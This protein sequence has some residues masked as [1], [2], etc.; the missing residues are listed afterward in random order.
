[1][2][3]ERK[4]RE[5][6]REREREREREHCNPSHGGEKALARARSERARVS[7]RVSVRETTTKKQ[8]K[9]MV[10]GQKP[11]L[12]GTT[13]SWKERRWPGGM[14][15]VTVS[16][17]ET[18]RTRQ[19]LER[20]SKVADSEK[21]NS[22]ATRPYNLDRDCG[23]RNDGDSVCEDRVLRTKQNHIPMCQGMDFAWFWCS[24]HRKR[25]R[26]AHVPEV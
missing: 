22:S 3:G 17:Y 26:N 12:E 16:R 5:P 2:P 6:E 23:N 13:D 15:A 24:E 20:P 8:R 10:T 1:M 11:E 7:E 4:A 25:A 19:K 9:G 18:T 14:Q 21:V